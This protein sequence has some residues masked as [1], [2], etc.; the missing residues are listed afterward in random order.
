MNDYVANG[1]RTTPDGDS[2][3]GAMR[4]ARIKALRARSLMTNG[5]ACSVAVLLITLALPAYAAESA[6]ASADEKPVGDK[7]IH[8]LMKSPGHEGKTADQVAKELTNPNN[9]LAKMQTKFQYRWY[10]GDLPGADDQD[11]F[12]VLFQPIFPFKLGTTGS[13]GHS[14][15]FVRPAIPILVDQ[16]VPGVENGR[17]GW[18]HVSALGDVVTDVAYGVTEKN[19]L[20]WALGAVST[21]PLASDNDVAGKHFRLGPEAIIAK[22]SKAGVIGAFPSHQWDV[23]G[24]GSD[25]AYSTT[26]CQFF[27]TATPGGA[28]AI[29]TQP[30][31]AYDWQATKWTIP[32]HLT[33]SKTV[34]L[35]KM[36]VKFEV[37][38]NYYVERPDAFAPEWLM[39][40]N[41]TPV[42]PNYIER[43]IRG[44]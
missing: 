7:S 23:T 5:A 42:I 19:G 32:L 18:D 41:I 6:A 9:S 24:W 1:E 40:F 12:S 27:L 21:L 4:A 25:P 28:W 20:V 44:L 22:I 8:E 34:I 38:T 37:E 14:V 11:N 16:P 39:S 31:L 29:G 43:L 15:L 13:G 30:T 36:P 3:P 33:V 2:R 26:S 17:F 35:G 10:R